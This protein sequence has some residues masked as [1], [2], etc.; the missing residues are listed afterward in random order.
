ML[1]EI[2]ERFKQGY[3]TTDFP[4]TDPELSNRYKGVPTIKCCDK[5]CKACVNVCPT[6][7]IIFDDKYN[8]DLSKC[9][10]CGDCIAACPNS[11]IEFSSDFRMAVSDKADLLVSDKQ[12]KLANATK[13]KIF[14]MFNRSLKLRVISTG[15]C[16]ACEAD[17]NVL[18]TLA[19][20]LGRFGIQV[21]ASPRHADGL[22]IT[23]PVTESMKT[24]LK[25]TYD[26]IPDPKLVVAVG[27]CALSG[28]IF[29]NHPEQNN[30]ADNIIPVDLYIPG[31]P[32]NP[33]TI[34]D[35]LLRIL[36]KHF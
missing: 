35:G 7:A 1:N 11:N 2:I 30:G 3:K 22:I 23:G 31:C 14:S 19:F 5:E 34:L 36:N 16:N 4:K 15:G 13:N 21:V 18:S 12:L 9:T 29:Q 24:A 25:D 20:D 6:D 28:G 33:Y 8:I 27:A 32:P 17:I 26:A 10:F